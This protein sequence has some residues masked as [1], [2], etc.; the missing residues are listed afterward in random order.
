MFADEE[1]LKLLLGLEKPFLLPAAPVEPTPRTHRA[2]K[3][4]AWATG[5]DTE[6]GKLHKCDYG[7]CEYATNSRV[8]FDVPL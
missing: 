8:N 5:M 3:R 7:Y 4:P 6:M 2:K 1:A